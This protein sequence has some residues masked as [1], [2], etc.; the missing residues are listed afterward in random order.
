MSYRRFLGLILTLAAGTAGCTGEG[1]PPAAASAPAPASYGNSAV[2]TL[3]GEVV[4][5][6]G[7]PQAAQLKI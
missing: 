2:E 6:P 1:Q 7:S 3:G 4:V 5:P